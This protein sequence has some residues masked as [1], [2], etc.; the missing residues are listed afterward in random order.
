MS[1]EGGS[2]SSLRGG[3]RGGDGEGG[4]VG[5]WA[6]RPMASRASIVYGIM[7]ESCCREKVEI[8]ELGAESTWWEGARGRRWRGGAG[9]SGG[10][11]SQAKGSGSSRARILLWLGSE[12]LLSRESRTWRAWS[13]G[14]G[15]S[16]MVV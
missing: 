8:G 13:G 11:R 15:V 7:G 10:A 4:D 9:E 14:G 16:S 3:W 6:G 1:R 12:R 5:G 2:T